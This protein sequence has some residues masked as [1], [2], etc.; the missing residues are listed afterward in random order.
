MSDKELFEL[1]VKAAGNSYSPYSHFKVGA[2]LEAKDGRVFTGCNIENASYSLT[3]C[4]ERTA[5][6]KAVSE[7]VKE[8]KS[9]AIAGSSDEFFSTPC[10]PCG[11][12]LQ[13]MSEFCGDDFKI[14]LSD[15]TYLLRELMPNRFKLNDTD[16]I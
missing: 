2:A 11:A 4:A 5:I 15:R 1:A 7:G 9:I 12:C 13:V 6:F 8:F 3:V 16:D 14:V 10:P